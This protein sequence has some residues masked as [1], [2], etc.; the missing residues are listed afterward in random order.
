[1]LINVLKELIWTTESARTVLTT[2]QPVS[3]PVQIVALAPLKELSKLSF[4][5]PISHVWP[6]VQ[7]VSTTTFPLT[8]AS[9]AMPCA[10]PARTQPPTVQPAPRLLETTRLSYSQPITLA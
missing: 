9:P 2:V 5:P 4:S 6:T 7:R 8:L 3:L 1:M 10:Q